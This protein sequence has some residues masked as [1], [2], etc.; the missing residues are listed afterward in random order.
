MKKILATFLC[1]ALTCGAFIPSGRAW[2]SE[3]EPQIEAASAIIYCADTGEVVW[4]KDADRQM[5]PASMTKLL[6]CL[7]AAE[8][9]D[10][11]QEVTVT[12]EATEV[13]PSKIYLEEGEVL[14]VEQL[15]YGALL[16]SGNDAAAALAIATA[17]SIEDFAVMMNER[18]AELGCENTNFVNPHGLS[19]EGQL[20]TAREMTLIAEEAL[21]NEIVRK[22]SGT[23]EYVIA[24]TNKHEAR[25]LKNYNTFVGGGTVRYGD[26]ELTVEKYEGVFGGKTGSLTADYCTMVTALQTGGVE[27]YTVIMG[28]DAISRFTDMKTLLD[29]G[30]DNVANYAA[31]K[32]GE[33]LG[34][35]RLLGGSVN[36][37]E[38]VAAEDGYVHLPEGA[39][40][41]LVTMECIYSDNLRAPVE[42]GQKIGEAH[43]Y[44]AGEPYATVDLLAGT[45]VEEGWFLSGL[46]ISNVQTVIIF[47]ALFIILAVLT[48]VLALR[49]KNKR[50]RARERQAKLAAEARKRLEREEDRKKRN[51]NF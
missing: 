6:T 39:A 38:A 19:E 13:I 14:T 25:E 7:L 37:V 4:E 9:L 24:A 44:V 51:W 3:A 40:K 8:N 15:I 50:Q 26:E 33:A 28:T 34:E 12:K 49:M 32:R 43:I 22:I 35:V 23:T 30:R 11:E 18:A 16:P 46:G 42:E 17:G 10:L 29:Y 21:N 27:V 1:A 20:T 48:A 5:E 2:A 41:S 45:S 36:K 31:F 47:V